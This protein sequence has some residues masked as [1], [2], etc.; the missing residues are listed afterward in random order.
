MTFETSSSGSMDATAS[1]EP[2]THTLEFDTSDKGSLIGLHLVNVI[3]MALTLMIYRFWAITR[4][5]TGLWSRMRFM[6]SPLEYSGS[7]I[8]IFKGFLRAFAFVFL[9]YLVLIVGI[10]YLLT[11]TVVT[12][13]ANT[14]SNISAVVIAGFYAAARFL[15]YRYRVNRTQWRGIRGSVEGT[16]WE[17]VTV[18]VPAYFLLSFSVGIAKPWADMKITGYKIRALNI[19]GKRCSFGHSTA[20]LWGPYLLFWFLCIALLA[21]FMFSTVGISL[22]VGIVQ[23]F[24]GATMKIDNANATLWNI[25][26]LLLV[27]GTLYA[28]YRYKARFW[29]LVTER[30]RWNGVVPQTRVT[31]LSLMWLSVGNFLIFAC[32]LGL[33]TPL[34]WLRKGSYIASN[35]R[36]AGPID[37][38][39]LQQAA[40]Q[41]EAAGEGFLGEFDLS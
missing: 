3:F 29:H 21:T 5:R 9:P 41:P 31:A 13:L 18:A 22:F 19:G 25:A 8:E 32:S 15:A 23:L 14:I 11:T 30:T 36:L 6:G 26:F 27:P 28:F 37:V 39:A 38:D 33:L 7:A 12:G 24:T 16:V 4:V 10:D 1:S 35:L 17:Y 34:A 20:G 40:Y 2:K